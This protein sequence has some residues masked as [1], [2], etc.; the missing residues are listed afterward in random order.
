MIHE[1]GLIAVLRQLHDE[2]DAAVA[3]A[4][5]WPADLP[6]EE[7]LARLVALNAARAREEQAGHI[8]WLRPEYQKPAGVQT[9]LGTGDEESAAPVVTTKTTKLPWPKTL[10]EQAAALRVAL[11]A[12][13]GVVS[14]DDLAKGFKGARAGTVEN[15]LQTL[16]SLGLAREV[17]A[18]KFAA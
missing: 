7:I 11:A 12:Q 15:L 18:C 5:G 6:D 3:A 14:A 1:R 8:R 9:V 17:E 10:P 2:L 4:Y 13:T 16:V